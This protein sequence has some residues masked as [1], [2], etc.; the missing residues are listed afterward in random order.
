MLTLIYFILILGV[1]VLVHEFGHFIFSKLFGVY[2]YEF[3]IG[4]GPRIFG[5]KKKKGKTQYNVRAFPIGGFVSLA[6]EDPTEKDPEVPKGGF[7]YN[8]PIWQR[9][10]IMAAGVFNNFLLAII[11]LFCIGLFHGSIDMTPQIS[12]ID[13]AYPMY[14]AG[15]RD[16]DIIK[17]IN[18]NKISTMDDLRIYLAL[19][20]D[21]SETNFVIERDGKE[22]KYSVTPKE[23]IDEE[24]KETVYKYGMELETKR[25]HGFFNA[26]KYSFEQLFSYFKQMIITFKYLFSGKLGADNL[27]GPVGIYSVVGKVTKENPLL[28]ILSL[29]A[30]LSVNVGFLNIMPFPAF[31]GGRIVFLIIEKLRGKPVNPKIENMVNTIGFCLLMVLVV[32]V[33][34]NDIVKLLR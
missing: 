25:K 32:F 7:L 3:S 26:I 12:K 21:G 19:E 30:L 1:I 22:Y 4:M 29:T 15:I 34:W 20:N 13:E 8:K 17:E 16:G 28:N 33:T 6:G 14:E 18:G 11:I 5:T 24:S 10:I 23:E 31:D 2:V 9:F 27:S